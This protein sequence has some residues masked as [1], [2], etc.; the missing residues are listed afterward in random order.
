MTMIR[1]KNDRSDKGNKDPSFEV[2]DIG[3]G[4]G[5][6]TIP[7]ARVVR[8]VTAIEP[9]REMT[10]YLM[11]NAEEEGIKNIEIIDRSWL[12]VDDS[13]I[14]KKFDV[15]ACSHLLWQ[16]RDV[17]RQLKWMEGASKGYCCVVHH[18]DGRD[19]IVKNLWLK[20]VG[21]E[22]RGELDPD[23]DDL[24]FFALRERGTREC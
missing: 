21:R 20:V 2:L 15:V 6:L 11:K 5:T 4:P 14:S 1:E 19:P 13:E 3:A 16:F 9:S 17:G 18:A 8:K 22:Y 24:V 12:E 23:R 7:F 10:K